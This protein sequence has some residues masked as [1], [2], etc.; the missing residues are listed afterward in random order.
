MLNK[1]TKLSNDNYQ[2]NKSSKYYNSLGWLGLL[3]T[4]KPPCLH[5]LNHPQKALT[6]KPQRCPL[7]HYC[8]SS[9]QQ[10]F[11]YAENSFSISRSTLLSVVPLATES[12]LT[13]SV[14]AV[15]S[16]RRS[17]NDSVF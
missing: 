15:S 6:D 16:M 14:R 3:P 11:A 17:P 8:G 7:G 4:E 13:M 1:Q 12:S 5:A 10:L 9:N 2:F